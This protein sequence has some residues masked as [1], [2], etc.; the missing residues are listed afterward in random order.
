MKTRLYTFF[1]ESHQEIFDNYFLPSFNIHLSDDFFLV[2]HRTP[3]V[4][5]SGDF[6]TEGFSEAMGLKLGILKKAIEE[7]P[8]LPFVYADCDIQFFKSPLKD[9]H[10]YL[11]PDVDMVAQDDV[12][13]I[14]AG[15]FFARGTQKFAKF[16]DHMIKVNHYYAND[17]IAINMH[18]VLIKYTLLPKSKY[19]TVGNFNGG[20]VWEGDETISIPSDIVMHH[21]NFTIGVKHKLHMLQWVKSSQHE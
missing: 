18:K 5:V 12:D 15:F 4:C 9:M 17:Q 16:I 2:A 19:L 8:D 6:N 13:T 11:T 1:S 21:A 20:V 14:C 3:Q 10:K 7:N